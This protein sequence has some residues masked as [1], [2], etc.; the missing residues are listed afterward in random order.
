MTQ[1]SPQPNAAWPTPAPSE[2]PASFADRM[3]GWYASRQSPRHRKEHGLYL[4][5]VAVAEYMAQT[6]E[7]AG[8]KL[9]ILDPAAGAGVLCCAVVEALAKRNQGDAAGRIAHIEI[10]A[11]EVDG[12][13]V[14]LLRAVLAHLAAWARRRGVA[15]AAEVVA[16]DF[17]AAHAG[18]VRANGE[19]FPQRR[20]DA[21][22]DLVI[23]NPPYFKIAK[24]DPRALALPE[25][26]HGQPNIYAL[27]MA[28]SA[29]L[30][31]A[32]GQLVFITPRSF[33]SG[34][35]F[36]RFRE[37]FFGL[38]QPRQV[39]VFRSRRSAFGR[40]DVL[41]E[42]VILAGMRRDR[43]QQD[44]PAKLA[45]TSSDGV[46]D[47]AQPRRCAVDLC[48]AIDLQSA[49]KVLRLPSSGEDKAVVRRWMRGRAA[50]RRWGSASRRARWCR[51]ARP[52]TSARLAVCRRRT[53]PCCG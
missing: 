44:V 3:G 13:L 29:A 25:L 19:L 45:V 22:F 9:R 53:C 39:H 50:C 18:A 47:M 51:S 8:P 36:R 30:L 4:T 28:V 33:A 7:V 21:A 17:I 40:D 20:Q 2:R 27:F 6:V 52:S 12:G 16:Q 42:N 48:M 1:P 41:Q 32:E 43:W 10:V 46:G 37:V 31:R 23:A 11:H 5:P 26:V 24:T 14:P 49:D 38:I 15:V 35:Y 34:P